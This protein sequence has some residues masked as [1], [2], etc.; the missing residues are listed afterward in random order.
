V[1]VAQVGDEAENRK[2]TKTIVNQQEP[3]SKDQWVRSNVSL[4]PEDQS[5]SHCRERIEVML[6]EVGRCWENNGET[7]IKPQYEYSTQLH[8]GSFRE[9]IRIK[10]S[11]E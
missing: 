8:I 7:R 1:T 4:T 6:G 9:K 5:V 3:M 10:I 11:L 2:L